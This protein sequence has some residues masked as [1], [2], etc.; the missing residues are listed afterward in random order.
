M[1]TSLGN[2]RFYACFAGLLTPLAAPIV[3][4]LMEGLRNDVV[5]E[6]DRIRAVLPFPPMS[7]REAIVEAI[8]CPWPKSENPRPLM[9][10]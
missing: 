2:V 8:Y 9:A 4:S 7:Y 3:E 10:P 1:K 6:N 5:C